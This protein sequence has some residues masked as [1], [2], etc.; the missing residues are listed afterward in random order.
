MGEPE[1]EM[2]GDS[3]PTQWT[4]AM[5]WLCL[6]NGAVGHTYGANGFWQMNRN[7]DPHGRSPHHPTGNG[8]G[9]IAWDDAMNLPGSQQIAI[10]KNFFESLPWT[11][12][13]PMPE[14]VSW[15]GESKADSCWSSFHV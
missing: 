13:T 1:Y 3:L 6:T 10:G 2:L 14:D 7:G 9:L 11:G 15:A 5:F 12:L 4:R 8:Y